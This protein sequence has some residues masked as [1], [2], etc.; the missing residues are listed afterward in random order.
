LSADDAG[1]FRSPSDLAIANF[2]LYLAEE[3]SLDGTFG[4]DGYISVFDISN[5]SQP[6]FIKRFQ[7]G[8]ELP[9]GFDI[10]HGINATLDGRSVYVASYASNYII[11]IDTSTNKV[12]DLWS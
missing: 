7:P 10:A 9:A 8:V 11:K 2:Q 5:I 4:D 12:K 1:V 6:R 3:D